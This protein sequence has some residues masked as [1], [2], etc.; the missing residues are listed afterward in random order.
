MDELRDIKPLLEIPDGSYYLFLT[1]V[2]LA[3]ALLLALI[4]FGLQRYWKNKKVEMQ[5]VYFFHFK[6]LDW[7]DVK[8]SAYEATKLGRL[9]TLENERAREIYEQLVPMLEA[10]KYRKEVSEV[11]EKTLKQ[12]N[13]LVH[14]ID[15]TL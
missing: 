4:G 9:L 12:Y 15:E 1:L 8:H 6:N 14:I 2:F 13:L 5:T 10:Y 7:S 11:D 3:I